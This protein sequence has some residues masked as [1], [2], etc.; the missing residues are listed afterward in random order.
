MFN[1]LNSPRSRTLKADPTA[2]WHSLVIQGQWCRGGLHRHPCQAEAGTHAG[3]EKPILAESELK[4]DF[5]A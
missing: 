5:F 3:G 4:V 1:S 2:R